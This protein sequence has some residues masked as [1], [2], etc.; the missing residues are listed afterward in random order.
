MTYGEL[1]EK[2]ASERDIS[3]ARAREI[4]DGFF[5]SIGEIL[6]QGKGVSIPDLGTFKAVTKESRTVYSPHH[7]EKIVVPPRRV[8]D[9]S[10]AKRLKEHLKYVETGDE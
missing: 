6:E 7:R 8:V 4:L 5:D 1:I 2:L 9:F 3:K 10:A